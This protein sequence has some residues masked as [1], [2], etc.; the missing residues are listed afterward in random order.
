MVRRQTP[1]RRFRKLFVQT[2]QLLSNIQKVE[3]IDYLSILIPK[4]KI[5][6]KFKEAEITDSNITKIF[7]PKNRVKPGKVKN[8]MI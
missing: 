6:K 2:S 8:R 4:K 3:L 5:K 7:F 1:V